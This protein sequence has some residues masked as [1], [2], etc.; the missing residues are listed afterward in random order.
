MEQIILKDEKFYINDI[1]LK[2]DPLDISVYKEGLSYSWKTLR[3]K[4][5]SKILNGNSI[6]HLKLNLIFTK[7]MFLDLHRLV[8]QTKNSPIVQIENEFVSESVSGNRTGQTFFT[9]NSLQIVPRTESPYALNVELDL[10]YFNH[11]VYSGEF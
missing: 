1:D 8:C 10:R 9:V 4:S 11:K 5:S 2:V 6:F 7:S 3:T